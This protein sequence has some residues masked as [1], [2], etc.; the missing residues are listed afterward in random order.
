[1]LDLLIRGGKLLDFN[2]GLVDESL[3]IKDGRIVYM[4]KKS[5]PSK[6][7]IELRG[8]IVS[9]GFIDIHMHEEDLLLSGGN[10]DIALAML[11]MGV[12]T[13]VAG[14]CGNNRQDLRTFIDHIDKKGS[15]INYMSYIGHN[16]L[17]E[18]VGNRDTKAQ[19]TP[20]QI[21]RMKELVLEAL[22]LGALGIS[23]GFEYAS[24]G[25][26][27]EAVALAQPLWDRQDLLLA[28]HYRYDG[29]RALESIEEMAEISR[30]TG[31]PFLISHL[32]SCSAFGFMK[33]SLDLIRS[34][35]EAGLKLLVDAYPYTAF[36]TYIGSDVFE[37]GCLEGWGVDYD[38]IQLTQAPY[39]NVR[40]NREIFE[41]ARKNHPR[42]LAIAHVMKEDEIALAMADPMVMVASDGIYRES[43]GHPRG[44][45]TFPRYISRYLR[46]KGLLEFTQGMKKITW[47]PAR[48]LGLRTKGS[49]EVGMDADITIFN[50]EKIR[51]CADFSQGQ[52]PP[53]GI[54]FV[55]LDGKLALESGQ[56]LREDLGK[57]IRK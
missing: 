2:R 26:L 20:Q 37:E 21:E 38:A 46:D 47:D 13:A 39:E 14:N 7:L 8:E 42:M 4:G 41:D 36:S 25:S 18:M 22:E 9:P 11:R 19:S 17:R 6:R 34:Y 48:A 31:V 16:Y 45:G 49:L 57:F 52:K 56:I 55:I 44:A 24:G 23:Y 15:P 1:M 35:R 5:P 10:Y 29:K 50:Y 40:C 3:G 12:T 28:A 43:R 27:E 53:Q 33:E 51:D 32:S 54:D 30:R